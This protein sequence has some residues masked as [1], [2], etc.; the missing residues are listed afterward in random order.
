M[1]CKNCSSKGDWLN[2]LYG[3]RPGDL[4]R[5]MNFNLGNALIRILDCD[6]LKSCSCGGN[7][8]KIKKDLLMA[9][10]YLSDELDFIE[11]KEDLDFS[12]SLNLTRENKLVDDEEDEESMAEAGRKFVEKIKANSNPIA[13]EEL[14]KI[15]KGEYSSESDY[16]N[17]DNCNYVAINDETRR[18]LGINKSWW[19]DTNIRDTIIFSRTYCGD[20]SYDVTLIYTSSDENGEPKR[21]YRLLFSEV[22]SI[23]GPRLSTKFVVELPFGKLSED[24]EDKLLS[25]LD[26]FFNERLGDNKIKSYKDLLNVVK[27]NSIFK[28]KN[29]LVLE[30]DTL[31]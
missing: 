2:D 13:L 27:N 20:Y 30:Y 24:E 17:I 1:C 26:K 7:L 3:L 25:S 18:K 15:C 8:D 22:D 6:C 16:S 29:D 11:R 14:K 4:A 10:E 9:I 31:K 19:V 5:N 12:I 21:N 23:I 28:F